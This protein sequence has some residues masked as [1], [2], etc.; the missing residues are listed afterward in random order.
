MKTSSPLSLR[1]LVQGYMLNGI[2]ALSL[3]FWGSIYAFLKMAGID[4]W[5][6]LAFAVLSGLLMGKIILKKVEKWVISNKERATI[7][8]VPTTSSFVF[9]NPYAMA[10]GIILIAVQVDQLEGYNQIRANVPT[11]PTH[12]VVCLNIGPSNAAPQS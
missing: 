8:A 7:D 5:S 3:V 4:H 1:N 10:S 12:E 9:A 11:R 2:I 6:V